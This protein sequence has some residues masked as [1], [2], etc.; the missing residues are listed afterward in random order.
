MCGI[1]G[2]VGKGDFN[3]IISMTKSLEHRGPDGEGTYEDASARLFF[4][5]RRLAIID[6]SHGQQPMWDA[7]ERYCI[8]YNGEIYNHH[9]LRRELEKKS[10]SFKTAYCDTEVILNGF[11]VWGVDLLIKLNGMF[12]FAIYDKVEQTVFLARDRFGEKPLY[13]TK[14]KGLFVFASE[15]HALQKHQSIN[16]VINEKAIQ[17]FFAYNYFPAPLTPYVGINKLPAAS[18]MSYDIKTGH[19]KKGK[20]WK[21]KIEPNKELGQKDI[22][23]VSEEL[24]SLLSDSVKSRLESDTPLGVFLSGGID[25]SA[26][27]G[28]AKKHLGNQTLKTFSIGFDEPTFDETPYALAVAQHF[29]TE[30][31]AKKMKINDVKELIPY[32]L[33]RLDEPLGDPSILPTYLLSQFARKDVAVALSG[34]G[35]DELFAGYDPFRALKLAQLYNAII[36]KGLHHFI[37]G[38]TKHLRP[39]EG[40]MSFGFKLRRTLEGLSYPPSLWNPVWMASLEPEMLQDM[41]VHP[42]DTEELFEE[43][44]NI[45]NGSESDSF[46][47]KSLEFYTELYMQNG[48]LTKT[49]RASMMV[50]LEVRAPFLDNHLVDFARKLPS[51]MKF[52]KGVTKFI[53]K[54]AVKDMLP[55][56]IINRKKKGFG[57]PLT[58]WLKEMPRPNSAMLA[59]YMS[60]GR[61]KNLYDE[62][63][64]G[65][66][67]HRQ[68]LWNQMSLSHFI[69]N[70]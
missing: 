39:S 58:R 16:A 6:Q 46:M 54:N 32:V 27:T 43:A 15:L 8:T 17:K 47:D 68:A 57:I 2:F 11:K 13:Y 28:L 1:A 66:V 19:L 60:E 45:W 7:S 44:I 67:D 24:L 51:W 61:L 65:K 55:N 64:A 5:H 36:P 35:G 40:N 49:D 52:N 30:H 4:G 10:V 38:I 29:E 69:R 50:S 41:A 48:I 70:D 25:S 62:H 18:W 9:A 23:E 22:P 56:E 34:D 42:M 12:S 59:P 63:V 14:E 21:F 31:F 3:D 53:L 26:I 33:D 20:Y 37:R